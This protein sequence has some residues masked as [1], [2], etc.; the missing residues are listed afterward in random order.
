MS[1]PI[2][3]ATRPISAFPLRQFFRRDRLRDWHRH[4]RVLIDFRTQP[5]QEIGAR[6]SMAQRGI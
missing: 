6:V 4:P 2:L 5:L 1:V 3:L